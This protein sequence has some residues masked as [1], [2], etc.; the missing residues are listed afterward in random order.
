MQKILFIS[1]SVRNGNCKLILEELQS[2]F[3]LEFSTEVIYI[4][5]FGLQPCSGCNL[6]QNN[7]QH[8]CVKDDK[9]D[10]LLG[11]IMDADIVVM[12]TPNYFYN[13]SGLTKTLIDKT[14]PCYNTKSLKGKK[15]I[16]IYVGNDNTANIK[17]RQPIGKMYVKAEAELSD[18][19]TELDELSFY[20][21]TRII[22]SFRNNRV[23]DAMFCATSGYGYDD[24]GRDT[25]DVI[26]A[27]LFGAEAALVRTQIVNGTQ[28]LTIG[29]FGLLRPGDTMLSV[30][31]KP[32]DTL[33]EVLGNVGEA[34][35]GSLKDFG[36]SY[37]Q[38]DLKD[39]K[40]DLEKIKGAEL[41]RGTEKVVY[42]HN[43]YP[44]RCIKI[45]CCLNCCGS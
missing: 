31:G 3:W 30:A 26:W 11:K 12:A 27:E 10:M 8:A 35:N 45:C 42:R 34:G 32:Y 33:D 20:H 37:R 39:G 4:R 16:Y 5:D 14:Y 38:I 44:D 41:G 9:M 6:C 29:L 21:T 1:G 28:A 2:K 17:N 7:T 25:L 15:F 19:F 13:V 43:E 22:D 24:K 18:I 36:I 23:S 40:L